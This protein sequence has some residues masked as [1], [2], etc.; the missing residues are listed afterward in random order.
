M[1][2]RALSG[3]LWSSALL[4]VEVPEAVGDSGCRECSL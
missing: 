3:H 4:V 1:C 2:D